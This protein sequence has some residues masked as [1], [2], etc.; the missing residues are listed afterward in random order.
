MG[1]V[2]SGEVLAKLSPE[3]S[4]ATVSSAY[5][6]AML[7]ALMGATYKAFRNRRSLLL[8][9]LQHQVRFNELPWVSAVDS[10]RSA[11]PGDDSASAART[12][13]R[14]TLTNFPGT[15]TPNPLVQE[16]D[17]LTRLNG[18]PLPFVE[19]LAADI[20]MGRFSTKFVAAAQRASALLS[21][22]LY[23]RYYDIDYHAIA[24]L[25][26]P[27]EKSQTVEAFNDLCFARAGRTRQAGS[28]LSLVKLVMQ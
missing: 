23:S 8:L 27:V 1:L 11:T 18:T 5:E 22:S 17:A 13:A 20:F 25:E 21:E 26:L 6:D 3:L 12:L 24:A 15:I 10:P 16:L 28:A 2:P 9:D 4:V 7:G 14:L 19:E